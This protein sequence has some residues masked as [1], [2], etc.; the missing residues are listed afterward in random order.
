M[1]LLYAGCFSGSLKA[2]VGI[3]QKAN[4]TGGITKR[5]RP[6][7]KKRH[8]LGKKGTRGKEGHYNG[9]VETEAEQHSVPGTEQAAGEGVALQ[10]HSQG[11]RQ[12]FPPWLP[13]PGTMKKSLPWS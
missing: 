1:S 10:W 3:S 2:Y 6:R 8:S 13:S 12:A 9:D 5:S 4:K 7:Q 11:L